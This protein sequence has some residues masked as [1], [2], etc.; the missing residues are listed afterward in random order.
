MKTTIIAALLLSGCAQ[1]G[2]TPEQAK[3]MEGSSASYCLQSL[4]YGVS[5]YTTF[6]GKSVGSSGGGG[7]AV[8]G[9]STVEFNNEGKAEK[10]A[11]PK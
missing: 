3:S 2:P 6:G 10:P 1:F 8:C 11:A 4:I 5:H 9:S 7:K